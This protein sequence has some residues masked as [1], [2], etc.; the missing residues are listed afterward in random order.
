M[1][2]TRTH[3]QQRNGHTPIDRDAKKDGQKVQQCTRTAHYAEC[4]S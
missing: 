3:V 1:F 4:K 2:I